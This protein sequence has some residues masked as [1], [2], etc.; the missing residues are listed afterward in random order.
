MKFTLVNLGCKVNRVDADT[1]AS[2]LM[3][4]GQERVLQHEADCILINTCTVT[5]GAEKKTRKAIRRALRESETAAVYVTGCAAVID[6]ASLEA[7]DSRVVVEPD[8]VKVINDIHERFSAVS[9]QNTLLTNREV[10]ASHLQ[11]LRT[12]EGF[13][14]RVGIKI[15]DGC[16]H[17]CSYCIVHK[18]RGAVWSKNFSE[19]IEEVCEYERAG[20]REVILTGINLGSYLCESG[21]EKYDLVSLLHRLL[22]ETSEVRFRI[23]SIEPCD[24]T[25]E[26]AELMADAGGRICRHLHLP[27]QSGSTKVLNEMARPYDVGEFCD[28]VEMLYKTVPGLSLSTDIIVGFPGETDEEFAETLM[29][30]KKCNFSKTHIFPYSPRKGT[31]AALR[32]D[33]VSSHVKS[34]RVFELTGL[35]D[36]LRKQNFDVRRGSYEQVL[37]E[38]KGKGLSESYYHIDVPTNVVVGSLQK[39]KL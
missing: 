2:Q 1:M 28:R 5:G 31:P 27:L 19:V 21:T 22:R 32:L 36:E 14:T 24:A 26:L 38:E 11:V 33:Q 15:Q 10:A 20:V 37:I 12:G 7:I 34:A 4:L 35:A 18:A 17:A 13:P 8:K 23:S 3:A 9:P 29:M 25:L 39:L 6:Q 30:V 16:E